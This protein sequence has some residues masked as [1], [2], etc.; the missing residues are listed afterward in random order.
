MFFISHS[1]D[2]LKNVYLGWKIDGTKNAFGDI[3]TPELILSCEPFWVK[4]N[5]FPMIPTLG[6]GNCEYFCY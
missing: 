2:L 4:V 3:S 6:E 1:G 5:K